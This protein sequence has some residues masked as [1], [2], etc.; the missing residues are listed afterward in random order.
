MHYTYFTNYNYF[1]IVLFYFET[2]NNIQTS[3][4]PPPFRIINNNFL[5]F[6]FFDSFKTKIDFHDLFR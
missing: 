3:K 6:K 4:F 1:Y 5:S 2:Q